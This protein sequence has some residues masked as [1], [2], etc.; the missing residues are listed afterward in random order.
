MKKSKWPFLTL[1][2]LTF[3][4]AISL[5]S[6]SVAWIIDTNQISMNETAGYTQGAYFA[7]GNGSKDDPYILNAPIHFY[8]FAWLQDMG[9]FNELDENGNIQT[10]Y[11]KMEA[12]LDMSGTEYQKLPPVGTTTYPF[13]GNFDGDGH[14]ISS[15]KTCNT[16][17][18]GEDEIIRKPSMV[19]S[20]GD[21]N[22][23]GVF[24]VVGGYNGNPSD[25]IYSS[26][27]NEIKDLKIKDYTI[28]SSTP[29]L[30]CGVVAGYVNGKITDVAVSNSGSGVT[31][32]VNNG[33]TK[34]GTFNNISDFGLVGYATPNFKQDIGDKTVNIYNT[35]VDHEETAYVFA[36]SEEGW[37]GTISMMEIYKRLQTYEGQNANKSELPFQK[38]KIRSKTTTVTDGG[39]PNVT[40]TYHN[41]ITKVRQWADASYPLKGQVVFNTTAD[42]YLWGSIKDLRRAYTEKE[43]TI[44]TGETYLYIG[45]N[46]QTNAYYMSITGN[47]PTYTIGR[48]TDINARAKFKTDAR[49]FYYTVINGANVYLYTTSVPNNNNSTTNINASSDPV[50]NGRYYFK[51]N[52]VY[53]RLYNAT[54]TLQNRGY[55]R[56]N[57]T[58]ATPFNVRGNN[59]GYAVY[60]SYTEKTADTDVIVDDDN[61]YPEERY[62]KTYLPLN[63]YENN[64]IPEK[65]KN[66]F[67]NDRNLVPVE[68]N[69]GQYCPVPGNTAYI[70][71]GS[72]D[73]TISSD[74][75]SGYRFRQFTNYQPFARTMGN[76]NT[77]NASRL[78]VITRTADT[79]GFTFIE[80]QYNKNTAIGTGVPSWTY[81]NHIPQA[82]RVKHSYEELGLE[83]YFDSRTALN[84]ICT[85]NTNSWFMRYNG[86]DISMEN[87]IEAD[88]VVLNRRFFTNYQLPESTI[89]FRIAERGVINMFSSGFRGSGEGETCE[90]FCS[91]YQVFRDNSQR[92]TG[93]KRIKEIYTNPNDDA[94]VYRYFTTTTSNT[95][96]NK[97]FKYTTEIDPITNLIVSESYD[98]L[99]AIP[100]G[101]SLKFDLNWLENPG[102]TQS[103]GACY[104]FE[105]PVSPGEYAIGSIPGGKQSAYMSYLDVGASSKK[106]KRTTVFV[107]YT[108]ETNEYT[109]PTGVY[110]ISELTEELDKN[111][112]LCLKLKPGF[113]GEITISGTSELTE[114]SRYDAYTELNFKEYDMVVKKAGQDPPISVVAS[115]SQMVMVERLTVLDHLNDDTETSFVVTETRTSVN[116]GAESLVREGIMIDARG[117]E[118]EYNNQTL[119]PHNNEN[120]TDVLFDFWFYFLDEDTVEINVGFTRVL[121]DSQEEGEVYYLVENLVADIDTSSDLEINIVAVDEEGTYGLL[122]NGELITTISTIDLVATA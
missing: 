117:N 40:Y 30:L 115:N 100:S 63:V 6:A 58:N 36:G 61:Y 66:T 95:A 96:E 91:L 85:T 49:G 112:T 15:L 60:G 75:E 116:G 102:F 9:K 42:R 5:I 90:G 55:L 81:L 120:I 105:W 65:D 77:Y 62:G 3:A 101:Y 52:G 48:T 47:G 31:F 20:L 82:N 73:H 74:Y 68:Q 121:D 7:R 70:I 27:A 21:A 64:T 17:G 69:V 92:I 45:Q 110:F 78:Q 32:K 67:W 34:L 14:S 18:P 83:R 119:D 107:K 19:S 1:A 59:S 118:A 109:I 87:I 35:H 122:I 57:G 54:G 106:S 89:D 50:Q 51:E 103:H 4:S 113:A 99:A 86:Q 98:E 111:K 93:F 12:D 53:L 2:C 94:V 23:M 39:T 108:I 25:A 97:Y 33:T 24:G 72:K 84:N 37:G 41:D 80:D 56:Y 22:I 44:T 43:E 13:V 16:L 104:Y 29:N 38:N 88:S 71:G 11:F 114:L 46:T 8:N 76:S 10:V 26:S 28:A 79:N